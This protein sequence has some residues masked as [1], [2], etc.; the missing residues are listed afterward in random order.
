MN[1]D[2]EYSRE[3]YIDQLQKEFSN[4]IS[5]GSTY[6]D[7]IMIY[8]LENEASLTLEAKHEY[9]TSLFRSL[10][11]PFV[12]AENEGDSAN[13]LAILKKVI[14][15]NRL[16]VVM[17]SSGHPLEILMCAFDK[18]LSEVMFGFENDYALSAAQRGVALNF[19]R[20]FEDE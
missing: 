12:T 5:A 19:D 15:D 20:F 3:N 10:Q 6:M 13:G 9:L 17:Q 8:G 1:S 11:Q 16:K 18:D 14:K 2:H 7:G 4:Q